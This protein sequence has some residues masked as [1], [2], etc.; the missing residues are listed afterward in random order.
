M[1]MRKNYQTWLLGALVGGLVLPFAGCSNEDDPTPNGP[2][3]GET[4]KAQFAINIPY[5]KKAETKMSGENTQQSGN[6]LGMYDIKL[7]PMTGD[8]TATDNPATTFSSIINLSAIGNGEIVDGT[9]N[10]KVYADVNIP[11]GTTNF[12]FY[13]VGGTDAPSTDYERFAEGVL[14]STFSSS[15]IDGIS[16]TLQGAQI[17][18]GT[19]DA[20]LL[21]VLNAV[22]Q[23]TDWSTQADETTLGDLYAS[24]ITL[25]AGSAKSVCE[26]LEDL[27]NSVDALA[28]GTDGA[29]KT[30]AGAIQSAITNGSNFS[31]SGDYPYTLTT[32]LTYPRNINMPDGAA[33]LSYDGVGKTFSYN[34]DPSISTQGVK[35]ADICF[36][37]SINYFIN[38]DLKANNTIPDQWPTT[39][40]AWSSGF[41]GWG[42]SV[43][44]ST[45]AIALTK[46]VQYGVAGLK[47]SVKCESSLME[48]SKGNQISV[49]SDGFTVTGVLVGGQPS[50]AGYDLCPTTSATFTKIVYDKVM[51]GTVAAKGGSAEGENYTL[52]LDNKQAIPANVPIIV[53]LENTAVGFYGK[54]QQYVPNGTKFYLVAELD[55]A[56]KSVSGVTI[57]WVFMQDYLTTASLTIKSLKNAENTIPDLVSSTLELGLAVD[58]TWQAGIVFNDV[59]IE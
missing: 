34:T 15:S 38:T 27:Y 39:L 48:D 55:P 37:A 7:L 50:Q 49:P 9:T 19:E 54:D 46:A 20:T 43:T 45:R 44:T 58:L 26:A 53:E 10:S 3:S 5:A 8:P 25:K 51:N 6:F 28:K 52:V 42:T 31:V 59:V 22:A 18:N 36:P 21:S 2:G 11:V 41:S 12:L 30:I 35:M 14:N 24:F 56:G 16:F 23:V 40:D 57:P 1:V 4:V 29:E 13:G 17:T 47:V 33:I 32:T